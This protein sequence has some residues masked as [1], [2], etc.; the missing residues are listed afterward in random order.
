MDIR[1][2]LLVH[3]TFL[4]VLNQLK[5]THHTASLLVDDQGLTREEGLI[6]QIIEDEKGTLIQLNNGKLIQLNTIVAV[7]GVFLSDYSEC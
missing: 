7:N 6:T 5:E 2:T 1:Q 4:Q 3:A